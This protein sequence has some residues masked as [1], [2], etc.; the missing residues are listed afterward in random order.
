MS[1]HWR[2]DE[3][4]VRARFGGGKRLRSLDEFVPPEFVGRPSTALRTGMQRAKRQRLP[5]GAKA[6]L[7]LVA[8]ACVGI[9]VALYQVMGPREV[10][11]PGA[12]NRVV[13]E[14]RR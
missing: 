10:V 5:D 9:A 8:A 12:E 14:Q 13:E 2:P 7:L 4:V 6:G 3:E 11:A 1:K